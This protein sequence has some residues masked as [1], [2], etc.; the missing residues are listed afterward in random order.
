MTTACSI[1]NKLAEICLPKGFVR[2]GNAFFRIQ[3]DGILQV[4]KPDKIRYYSEFDI[5]IGLFSMYSKLLPQWFSSSGCIPKYEVVNFIGL[6]SAVYMKNLGGERYTTRI[7]TMEQQLEVLRS[8]VLP[9]L[10]AII[11]QKQLAEGIC[12]LDR[13]QCGTVLWVD[14]LKLAPFLCC[15]NYDMAYKVANAIQHQYEKAAI[16]NCERMGKNEF[17]KIM[18]ER[19]ERDEEHIFKPLRLTFSGDPQLIRDYLRGNYEENCRYANFILKRRAGNSLC[20]PS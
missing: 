9:F 6:G 12:E 20:D 10:D 4:I 1:S 3:G 11:S 2:K 15:E 8:L 7:I 13:K 17:I 14:T 19:K 18:E 16:A 5:S